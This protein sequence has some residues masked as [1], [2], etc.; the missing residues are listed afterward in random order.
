MTLLRLIKPKAIE[1]REEVEALAKEEEGAAFKMEPWDLAY[2]SQL[3]KKKK[4]DLDPEIASPLL[5][6]RQCN[7]RESLAW[8]H[9]FY[10]ITFKENKDIPVYHP[11]VKPL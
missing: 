9:V 3:L 7:S 5:G 10:G 8:L 2:Y 11:D 6:V 1:E 4:Y